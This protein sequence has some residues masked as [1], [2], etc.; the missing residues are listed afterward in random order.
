MSFIYFNCLFDF[1]FNIQIV[2]D[3]KIFSYHLYFEYINRY[4]VNS[5]L[6]MEYIYVY[7]SVYFFF[8][9]TLKSGV[10]NERFG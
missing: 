10:M 4:F 9:C 8:K 3:P 5:I 7:V 1:D 6:K 2:N